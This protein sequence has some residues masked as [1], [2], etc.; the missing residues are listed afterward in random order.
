MHPFINHELALARE[1][2]LRRRAARDRRVYAVVSR[3]PRRAARFRLGWAR[4]GWGR[5]GENRLTIAKEN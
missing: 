2:D 1:A 5:R 3:R 4:L